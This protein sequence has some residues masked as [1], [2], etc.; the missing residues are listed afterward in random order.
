MTTEDNLTEMAVA[1]GIDRNDEWSFDSGEFPKVILAQ[2]VEDQGTD[3]CGQCG[4]DLA[5]G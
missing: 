1:F 3:Y 2:M 4:R 5:E